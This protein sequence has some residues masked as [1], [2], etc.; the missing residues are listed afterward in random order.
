MCHTGESVNSYG[1]ESCWEGEG[2]EDCRRAQTQLC[3]ARP[4]PP[5]PT[6]VWQDQGGVCFCNRSYVG[7]CPPPSA[8]TSVTEERYQS[9]KAGMERL[10]AEG[11]YNKADD[12]ST[13]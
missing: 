3:E 6:C 4:V 1:L 13:P 8:F 12:P 10:C 9:C 5:Q 11:N 2:F 7:Q